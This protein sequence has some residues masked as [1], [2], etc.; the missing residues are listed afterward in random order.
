MASQYVSDF[1]EESQQIL[2][3]IDL[4]NL[5]KMAELLA[6]VKSVKGRLFL[7]APVVELDIAHMLLAI[8]GNSLGSKATVLLIMSPN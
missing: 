2:R 7:S 1:I 5:D 4:T 8:L 3:N 6:N